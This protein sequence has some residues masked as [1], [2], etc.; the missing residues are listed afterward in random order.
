MRFHLDEHVDHAIARGL[1]NRGI[2]VTTAT[3]AGLLGASDEM[4]GKVEFV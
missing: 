2:E 1:R 4:I 3:D